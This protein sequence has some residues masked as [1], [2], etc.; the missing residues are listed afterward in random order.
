MKIG[1]ERA[2]VAPLSNLLFPAAATAAGAPAGSGIAGALPALFHPGGGRASGGNVVAGVPYIVGE[3]RPE[4]FVP[5][6]SGQI[7]PAVS[8]RAA[9]P[10]IV[11]QSFVLDNRGGVTTQDLIDHVNAIGQQALV[12]GARLGAMGG[13]SEVKRQF[14]RA[15]L[16][17]GLG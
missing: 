10:T 8:A 6:I 15:V 7:A 3:N 4:V 12:G 13:V 5:P 14:S 16:P 17:R 9:A 11:Q 1:I 2:I